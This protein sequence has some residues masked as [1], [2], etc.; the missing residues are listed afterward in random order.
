MLRYC[1]TDKD[2][3]VCAVSP[4]LLPQARRGLQHPLGVL[5]PSKRLEPRLLWS[6]PHMEAW[7][8]EDWLY[9]GW[10]SYV[11]GALT[12]VVG[13]FFTSWSFVMVVRHWVGGVVV[14]V[15]GLAATLAGVHRV[16]ARQ[17]VLFDPSG[18][19]IRSYER[20][21]G[22]EYDIVQQPVGTPLNLRLDR[23]EY[24]LYSSPR[25]GARSA[26]WWVQWLRLHM[27]PDNIGRY[28]DFVSGYRGIASSW[29]G[30]RGA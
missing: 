29:T 20:L 25:F 23:Y 19:F 5:A 7:K 26:A 4:P 18:G 30:L 9:P 12:G 14:L 24:L 17:G 22:W 3:S 8:Y 11:I 16:R 15:I 1:W 2:S 6:L 28:C 13:L 27:H 10:G 21:L